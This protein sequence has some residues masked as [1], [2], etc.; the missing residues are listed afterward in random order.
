MVL[1]W[2]CHVTTR[3]LPWYYHG[4]TMVLTWYYHRITMVLPWYYHGTTMV[5]PWYKIDTSSS[6]TKVERT[7]PGPSTVTC[8]RFIRSC[9]I[10][11]GKAQPKNWNLWLCHIKQRSGKKLIEFYVDGIEIGDNPLGGWH[12]RCSNVSFCYR[13]A[14]ND[15]KK[16]PA[17]RGKWQ[18]SKNLYET[19]IRRTFRDFSYTKMYSF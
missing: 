18:K 3:V 9:Q 15:Q 7:G 8:W 12:V 14:R 1:P 10:P 6:K 11:R 16:A 17:G 5:L 2:Y 13:K 4:T 19:V